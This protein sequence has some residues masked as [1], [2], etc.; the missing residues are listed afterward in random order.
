MAICP[1]I[2]TVDGG[3]LY[4][5]TCNE[6]GTVT[7][8]GVT[9]DCE[10]WD[11]TNGKCGTKVTNSIADSSSNEQT[12][13]LNMLETVVGKQSELDNSNSL[14]SYLNNILGIDSEK[15]NGNSLLL[16]LSDVI[17]KHSDKTDAAVGKNIL[18]VDNHIHDSHFHGSSHKASDIPSGGGSRSLGF[19]SYP[20][21]L[22]EELNS[23]SD[24]DGNGL[25]YGTDFRLTD[26]SCPEGL[27]PTNR[28]LSFDLTEKDYN[29]LKS[30]WESS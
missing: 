15:D 30:N 9:K 20:H 17:G 18:T 14:I 23:G 10:I 28:R 11:S 1:Y 25:V 26:D 21:V 2:S 19:Q 29:T 22:N 24:K 3:T 13:L 12:V 16:Y 8:D 7:L 4:W 27:I 6:D 5:A